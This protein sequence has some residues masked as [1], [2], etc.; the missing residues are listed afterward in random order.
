[1]KFTYKET[2]TFAN[3]EID[4]TVQT[5]QT[6]IDGIHKTI[7]SSTY[8]DPESSVNLPSDAKNLQSVIETVKKKVT[9]A[10][11]YVVNIG[12]GGSY[13]GT[14][15]VYDALY[16]AYDAFEEHR[17]PKMLFA[18][19]TN[20]E[21][22]SRIVTFIEKNVTSADEILV[23]SISKSGGTTET[24][25]NTELI[26]KA[27]HNKFSNAND[28]LVITTDEGSKYQKLAETQGISTLSIPKLVGGRYSVLSAVGLFPLAAIGIDIQQILSGAAR[29]RNLCLAKNDNPAAISAAILYLASKKGYVINDNFFFNT[30]LESLGKWY[31]QL[32]GESIG[33]EKSTKGDVI[34]A[35]ITPTV[36][37]GSNDLHSVVQLYWGGPRDKYTTFC[38]NTIPDKDIQTPE[39]LAFKGLI[40]HIE[41]R[42]ASEVM[43]AIYG[44]VKIAYSSL[45]LPYTE[46]TFEGIT[47]EEI[48]AYLQFKMIEMM[49]LGKL[50][51]VNTFDQPN[52]ELYKVETKRLLQNN[53]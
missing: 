30:Q 36:S 43:A 13:L 2:S 39:S 7:A 47:P 5:L 35:G 20:P 19:T 22:M 50:L 15:A 31:R 48:G 26:M 44:S 9:P 28:R 23:N 53:T 17:F 51:D 10:L 1:M 46:I 34:H 16:G 18:D 49:F 40:D 29:M 52:V 14:K 27:L 8:Q 12:I 33:K 3:S 41:N 4:A 42:K 21:M 25:V 6:Y 45:K 37:I 24:I 38:W 11:K 32:M